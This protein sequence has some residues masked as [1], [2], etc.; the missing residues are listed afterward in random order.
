MDLVK[1]LRIYQSVFFTRIFGKKND[2][3]RAGRR[4]MT[5]E[6]ERARA[7][8]RDEPKKPISSS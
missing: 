2:H 6:R 1:Y 8:E 4:G 7:I 5:G 3:K